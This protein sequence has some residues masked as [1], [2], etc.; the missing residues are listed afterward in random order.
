MQNTEKSE[1]ALLSLVIPFFNEAL[2]FT[3]T[4]PEISRFFS[5]FPEKCELIFV[6][7]GSTDASTDIL[8]Q[9]LQ[10]IPYCLLRNPSNQGKGSAVRQGMLTAKGRYILFSDADLSTPLAEV[11]SFLPLL[12]SNY[13]I[14]IGSRALSESRVEIHQNWMREFMGKVFN[15]IARLLSFRGIQDSQCG[16]KCFRRQT[17]HDLFSKQK[18]N[19]FAFDAEIL[20]IAQKRNCR[21]LEKPVLWRNEPQSRVHVLLDPLRMFI[22]LCKI[23]WIHRKTT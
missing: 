8:A 7:D 1:E 23:R 6:D 13:D 20:Y 14:V 12:E 10:T 5:S 19:G 2:R 22:D 3:K 11:L 9:N 21:I 15:R 4:L 17:A 18:L 16:F